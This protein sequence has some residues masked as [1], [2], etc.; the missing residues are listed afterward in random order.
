MSNL[1]AVVHARRPLPRLRV[2]VI[3]AVAASLA[4][5]AVVAVH[6]RL[7]QAAWREPWQIEGDT[8]FYLM[9]LRGLGQH[10]SYLRNPSLGW[11][12]GQTLYDLPQGVDNLHLG[13]LR[14]LAAVA[15][16]PGATINLF[17]VLT[18]PAVA[19]VAHLCLR[20]LGVGRW[21]SA[22]GA[23]LYAIAPYHF[24]RNEGHLLLSGYELVPV[25]VLLALALFEEPLPFLR[26][27]QPSYDGNRPR[28]GLDLRSARTWWIVLACIGLASTGAYYFAFS[29]M[30]VLVAGVVHAIG[31]SRWRPIVSAG[32]IIAVSGI[33]FFVNVSPTL[34]YERHHGANTLVNKR[35]PAETELYGLKI[36]QLFIPRENHRVAKLSALSARSQSKIV[37]LRSEPGQQL[38]I[39]GA[40][41]L[42]ALLALTVVHLAGG[43]R[44]A[45]WFGGDDGT[46]LRRVSLLTVVCMLVGAVGGLSYLVS[47]VGLREIRSWNRISIV[48]AFLT[49]IVIALALDRVGER[50]RERIGA[51]RRSGAVEPG[52]GVGV[53]VGR[54][55]AMARLAPVVLGLVVGAVGFV[56]QAGRD[57]PEYAAVHARYTTDAAFF[58]AVRARL[59]DGASVFNLPHLPFPE[60]G[61]R[62]QMG[63]YD[64]AVG[65][66]Y[67]P[68]LNW[69]FGFM[70]G[71]E[72]EYPLALQ[73]QP[74]EEWLTSVAAI[75]FTGIVIDRRGYVPDERAVRER[76]LA[77]LLGPAV[78]ESGG[79][80]HRYVFFDVRTF[81]AD[82]AKRLGP[83][84]VTARAAQALALDAAVP[85][86]PPDALPAPGG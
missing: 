63:S 59:G 55:S 49:V 56:D 36:S 71:R 26:P 86:A 7:W 11:P 14:L 34:L 33:A 64:Q 31:A 32:L 42:A 47:S 37:A 62:Y 1:A 25:G 69:S 20:R 67:E 43:R 83:D 9:V 84:G 15:G 82:V 23:F 61:T 24:I 19:L 66:V 2:L 78:A 46:L 65:Y 85:V 79:S 13:V 16:G 73:N 75:G 18:F 57:G 72:P 51:R 35:T 74:V 50:L 48:I 60:S 54:Y 22:I 6:F 17:Y 12:F 77:T 52:D 40:L 4:T 41:A 44:A 8:T 30:L 29:M 27:R 10:G 45:R 81:A 5:L 38:G 28:R 68:T 39:L 58:A 21:P 76:E 80:E 70:H 53:G 3:E